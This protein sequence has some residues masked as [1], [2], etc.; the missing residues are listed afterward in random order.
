MA[1]INIQR[2]TKQVPITITTSTASAV[3][4]YL[5]D[6]AGGSIS[7]GTLAAAVTTLQMWGG[8]S[9]SDTF[10]RLYNADGS[11]ADITLNP[12][13]AVGGVYSLPDAV[14]GVPCLEIVAAHTAATGASAVVTLKS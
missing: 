14:F 6:F 12:S 10:R 3:T 11:S 4:L 13:T 1:E 5:D 9:A 2:R 7:V 8:G